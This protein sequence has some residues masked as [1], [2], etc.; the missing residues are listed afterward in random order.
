MAPDSNEMKQRVAVL[1]RLKKLL[2]AQRDKFRSYLEV[3]EH[4]ES[5]IIE[6]DTDR[7]E[8]H[9]ALERSIVKEIYAFQRVIDPL[10]DMYD[11]AYPLR[12]EEFEVPAI[13][14]SLERI[15]EEVLSRNRHNQELLSRNMTA[16]R[17]KIKG[18][19]SFRK[20]SGLLPSGT[21]PS[22]IDTTA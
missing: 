19:R 4:E 7:L 21:A 22:L 3:L 2:T 18:I 20:L 16:V 5:D 9:V 1:T 12:D 8:A 6:G 10:E 13:K 15:K 11:M 17:E 14:Q